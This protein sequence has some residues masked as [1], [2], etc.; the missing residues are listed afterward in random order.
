MNPIDQSQL[1]KALQLMRDNPIE[2]ADRLEAFAHRLL[3]LAERLRQGQ[4]TRDTGGT[5]DRVQMAVVG[6]DGA[7]KQQTATGGIP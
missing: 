7:I 3:A 1:I 6:P 5:S 4:G 2:T